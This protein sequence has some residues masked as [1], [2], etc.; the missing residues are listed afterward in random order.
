M[1]GKMI[2]ETRGA[3][4]L[5]KER[6]EVW[7]KN[8]EELVGYNRFLR[9]RKPS[10]EVTKKGAVGGGKGLRRR[11][12]ENYGAPWPIISKISLKEDRGIRVNSC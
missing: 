4:V 9:K 3:A 2:P 11:W 12:G 6:G 5:A 10:A 1:Y 8:Q 7:G